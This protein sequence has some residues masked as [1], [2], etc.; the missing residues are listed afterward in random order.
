MHKVTIKSHAK[1][2]LGLNIVGKRADGFHDIETIFY[3]LDLCDILTFS[4]AESFSLLCDNAE[5]SRDREKNLITK[6]VQLLEKAAGIRLPVSITLEKNIPMGA[7]LGGG[8]SNAAVTLLSVNVIFQLGLPLDK[9]ATLALQ[10]GSDVPYFLKLR[11][12][13]ATARGEKLTYFNSWIKQHILVVNPGIHVSTAWAYSSIVPS[14]PHTRLSSFK[15]D[16][17]FSF[18][19]AFPCMSNDFEKPVFFAHPGIG[20]IKQQMLECGAEMAMMSG[21]GSTVYGIF[22]ELSSAEA[23]AAVLQENPLVFLEKFEDENAALE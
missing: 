8:S 15:F 4:K 22:K 7:G 5:L 16:D 17:A 23:A 13:F 19:E 9:L 18:E 11:P 2:N 3:P 10:L 6:A 20:K 12:A 1:I 21:S 14:I